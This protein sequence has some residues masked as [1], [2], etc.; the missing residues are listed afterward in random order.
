M[1]DLSNCHEIQELLKLPM[2]LTCLRIQFETLLSVPNLSDLT[3]LDELLLSNYKFAGQKS[4]RLTG[5]KLRWNEGLAKLK[6]L[7]V[8]SA[9]RPCASRVG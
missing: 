3:N 1:L 4:K 5:C 8:M 2:S 9:R 7:R 6:K